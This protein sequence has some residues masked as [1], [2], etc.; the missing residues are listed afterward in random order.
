MVVVRVVGL[1]VAGPDGSLVVS[2]EAVTVRI[3]EFWGVS[4]EQGRCLHKKHYR[5]IRVSLTFFCD[6]EELITARDFGDRTSYRCGPDSRLEGWVH[7]LRRRG[8]EGEETD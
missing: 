5:L 7:G 8:W 6:A 3:G 2:P 1:R 4:T